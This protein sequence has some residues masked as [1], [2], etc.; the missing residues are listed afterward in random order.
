MYCCWYTAA[1]IAAGTLHGI[2]LHGDGAGDGPGGTVVY[3]WCVCGM[4]LVWMHG[5]A[6]Y[7]LYCG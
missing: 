3:A 1:S 4:V 5:T 6:V 2:L 7:A